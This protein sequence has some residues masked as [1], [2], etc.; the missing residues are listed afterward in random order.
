[1]VIVHCITNENNDYPTV[2]T[3]ISEQSNRDTF[4]LLFTDF[5]NSNNGHHLEI[6]FKTP[7]RSRRNVLSNITQ[8]RDFL[9]GWEAA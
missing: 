4:E 5:F 8:A 6:E 2:P 3:D 1:M 7:H 9:R